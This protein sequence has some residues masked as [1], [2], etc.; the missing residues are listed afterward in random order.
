MLKKII[1]ELPTLKFPNFSQIFLVE[2]DTSKLSIGVVLCQEGHPMDFFSKKLN[3][4]KKNYSTY[5]LELYAM[6]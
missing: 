3:E 6:V 4:A 2:C 5:D 1:V